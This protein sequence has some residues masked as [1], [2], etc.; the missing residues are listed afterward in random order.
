MKK[1]I[2]AAAA[3]F[4]FGV[5]NAQEKEGSS[6]G[7]KNG[8]IFLSGSF[9]VGSSK[10]TDAGNYKETSFSVAPRVG[11]FVTDNIAVGGFLGYSSSK[12]TPTEGADDV[13]V[14]ALSVGA[15]GRYYATPA[16]KFSVFGQ[17][18][19]ALTSVNYDTADY[20][21]NGFDIE[22]APGVSYFLNSNFAIEASWGALSYSTAKADT[23][24]AESSNSF[25]I[26]LDLENINFGLL[27]KF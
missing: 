13:K 17:L 16:S 4:A 9:N 22:L 26:G 23:D 19:A 1:L 8:D 15:F 14:N 5:S 18:G 12:V 21:V 25:N 27:Y 6:E 24:G 20:K 11:F 3:L 10:Y 7:F 2:F